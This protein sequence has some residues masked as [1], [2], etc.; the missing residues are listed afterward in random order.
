MEA[1]EYLSTLSP[2]ELAALKQLGRPR[3]WRRGA[4]LFTE[5]ECSEWVVVLLTGRVKV[6][7]F[8]DQGTETLLAIRGAGAL[9]GELAAIDEQPRSASVIALE[10]VEA[11]VV[12]AATFTEFLAIHPGAALR[13]L[14]LLCERLRDA[15]RK[16]VEHGSLDTLGRL[17]R[18]LVELAERFGEPCETGV[19]IRMSLSQQELA[20]WIG[21]S[22]EAAAKA[23]R[24]LRERGW[25][26]TRRREI[27]VTNL[28][29]LRLR[30][31]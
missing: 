24:T 3:R 30:T 12:P 4:S 5:G 6:C 21:S 11:L 31:R 8:T 1:G 25:I 14:R 9:L 22:R 13:L 18:R 20:G 26:E 27:T 17:A 19:R 29:E 16:R 15:D 2:A 10:P 28:D 23:L 7:N